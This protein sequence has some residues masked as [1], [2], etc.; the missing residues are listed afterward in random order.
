MSFNEY[1]VK[2]ELYT[3]SIV[4]TIV[5]PWILH[6]MYLNCYIVVQLFLTVIPLDAMAFIVNILVHVG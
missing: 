4:D 2:A 3:K 5:V 1:N 6:V